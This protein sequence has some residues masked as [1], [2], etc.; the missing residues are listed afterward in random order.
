MSRATV[1]VD[2]E[3][4]QLVE[5]DGIPYAKVSIY[6]DGTIVDTVLARLPEQDSDDN[7]EAIQQAP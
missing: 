6:L 2:A 5:V 3:V 1:W 7:G 4:D